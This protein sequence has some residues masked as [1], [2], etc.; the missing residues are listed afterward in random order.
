MKKRKTLHKISVLITSIIF[1]C[2]SFL[3]FGIFVKADASTLATVTNGGAVFLKTGATYTMSGGSIKNKEATNGGAIYVSESATFNMNGGTISGNTASVGSGVYVENGGTYNM[4]GGTMADDVYTAGSMVYTGG[5]VSGDIT[6]AG[7]ENLTIG[8][9]PAEPLNVIAQT[10]A[11]GTKLIK[12]TA[13]GFELSDVNITGLPTGRRV[14][15]SGGYVVV[16]HVYYIITWKNADGTVLETDTV[17]H[18][19]TP[20]YDGATPTKASTEQY[21]YAFKSWDST[22][23]AATANKTYTATY[24][25][26]TRSYVVTIGVSPSEYGSV[27]KT[28]VTVPYGTSISASGATLTIG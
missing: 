28:S 24:T 14:I 2:L 4:S 1:M 10:T 9:V 21:S 26:T 3:A 15:L 6:L 25:A 12:V 22:V 23:V 16:D 18:G 20:T 5:T 11:V 19:T 13:S 7:S 8:A 27:S 17:A